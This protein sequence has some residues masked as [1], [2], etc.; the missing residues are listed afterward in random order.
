MDGDT[1]I[2]VAYL[3]QLTRTL[4]KRRHILACRDGKN[5][6]PTKCAALST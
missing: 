4:Y 5:V 1:E 3:I 2:C 6:I